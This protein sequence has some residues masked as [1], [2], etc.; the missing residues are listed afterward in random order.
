LKDA[1]IADVFSGTGT[2]GFEALSRGASSVVFMEKDRSAFEL[3]KKNVQK[4][5][6]S[7]CTFTWM[8]DI[9]LTSYRPKNCDRFLPYDVVFFD[10]PYKMVSQIRS[11]TMFYKSL[12]RLAKPTITA[13]DALVLFRTPLE[14]T[15][16]L[17]DCWEIV[18]ELEY[19][20]MKI[21]WLQK[22]GCSNSE[23]IPESGVASLSDDIAEDAGEDDAS[24]AGAEPSKTDD[25]LHSEDGSD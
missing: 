15:F 21:Y 25:D 6:A 18:A 11:G 24:E 16:E 8:N 10:P 17:P 3:L 7:D 13:D 14:S 5:G 19:P 23:A 4:L 1:K 12:I 9:L 2:M 20:T 22:P